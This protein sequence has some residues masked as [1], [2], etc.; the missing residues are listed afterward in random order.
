MEELKNGG[1]FLDVSAKKLDD[2][3]ALTVNYSFISR[4]PSIFTNVNVN[5][6]CFILGPTKLQIEVL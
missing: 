3:D 1:K 5:Y 2:L 6:N 4:L